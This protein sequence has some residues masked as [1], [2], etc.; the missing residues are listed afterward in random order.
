MIRSHFTHTHTHSASS[1]M[2]GLTRTCAKATHRDAFC[3]LRSWDSGVPL[4][5]NSTETQKN[6]FPSFPEIQTISSYGPRME[7][8]YGAS[9]PHRVAQPGASESGVLGGTDRSVRPDSAFPLALQF[10]Q[11]RKSGRS[12]V[13]PQRTAATKTSEGLGRVPGTE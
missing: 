6:E 5:P 4:F 11:L 3:L 10:L 12:H 8:G 13:P 2:K 1:F 9:L 7:Q